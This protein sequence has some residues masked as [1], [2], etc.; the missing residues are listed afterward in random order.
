MKNF[1]KTLS[2]ICIF[3]LAAIAT[4]NSVNA[5]TPIQWITRDSKGT[6]DSSK[7]VTSGVNNVGRIGNTA[8][9]TNNITFVTREKS[10]GNVIDSY[11]LVLKPASWQLYKNSVIIDSESNANGVKFD[12]QSRVL[13]LAKPSNVKLDIKI[14]YDYF[15]VYG[16]YRVYSDTSFDKL[17]TKIPVLCK[18]ND[19]SVFINTDES[20]ANVGGYNGSGNLSFKNIKITGNKKTGENFKN[21]TQLKDYRI[22]DT[23]KFAHAQNIKIENCE[24]YTGRVGHVIELNSMKDVTVSSCVFRD[25]VYMYKSS[26]N[27]NYAHYTALGAGDKNTIESTLKNHEVIQFESASAL[28]YDTGEAEI[29]KNWPTC[30]IK[31]DDTV[32]KNITVKNCVFNDVIRGVG[33]HFFDSANK[34]FQENITVQNNQFQN[35]HTTPI[36]FQGVKHLTISGNTYHRSSASPAEKNDTKNI[37]LR[38]SFIKE[39]VNVGGVPVTKQLLYVTKDDLDDPLNNIYIQMKWCKL[40]KT[41]DVNFDGTV[42]IL[43]TTVIQNYLAKAITLTD[44]QKEVADVNGDGVVTNADSLEIQKY[45]ANMI[46]V[47]PNGRD[48]N[49]TVLYADL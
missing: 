5:A 42:S 9:T 12:F 29:Y 14:S 25:I 46:V 1:L 43:D 11:E 3:A 48:G 21:G 10:T 13:N 31:G 4:A 49:S 45:L 15:D 37:V 33:D 16:P 23:F 36:H 7:T 6:I 41:G 40:E 30:K 17:E 22:I 47:F 8:G 35:I 26:T 32:S 44:D 28:T 2:L 34:I 38:N 20:D 18:Q 24:V 39:F 19:Y 27:V